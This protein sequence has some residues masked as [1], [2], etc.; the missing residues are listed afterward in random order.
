M[1]SFKTQV[2][3][4]WLTTFQQFNSQ[5]QLSGFRGL[6]FIS[7]DSVNWVCSFFNTRYVNVMKSFNARVRNWWLVL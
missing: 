7:D 1:K 5:L 4:W 6:S 2:I 3:N